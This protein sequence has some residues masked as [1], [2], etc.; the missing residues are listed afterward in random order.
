M[1]RGGVAGGEGGEEGATGEGSEAE[2]IEEESEEEID[3]DA[4]SYEELLQLGEAAGS[5]SRGAP[6]A[7]IDALPSCYF[8][9][10]SNPP[11]TAIADHCRTV[12]NPFSPVNR[13]LSVSLRH[14]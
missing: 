7:V 4:M 9:Q 2:A 1:R 13:P 5:V 6:A 11:E 12:C 3:V 8:R 10:A 14:A